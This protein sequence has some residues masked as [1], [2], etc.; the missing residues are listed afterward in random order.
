MIIKGILKKGEYFD[1]ISLMIVAGRITEMD[2][3]QDSAVVMGT[4]ENKAILEA[5]GFLIDMFKDA[6]DTDLLIAVKGEDEAVVLT[7]LDKAEE[8]LARLR[9]KE[10]KAGEFNP[11]SIEGAVKALPGANLALIS[12]AGKYAAQEAC[13]A[14]GMGL[15]VMIFSDNVSLKDEIRLK[16]Y[17]REHNLLVMGPDCGTAI[18]NGVPLGFA[19]AVKRGNIGVIAA[20]G[21]GLQEVTCLIHNGGGGIS[22]AVGTGGRD[23]KEEVGGITFIAALE[24]LAADDF[25][26]A[27]LLV[28]KPPHP[29]VLKKIGETVKGISKPVAAV[30]LG[31]E[32]AD[33]EAFGMAAE[34]TLQQGAEKILELAG[35]K[36]KVPLRFQNEEDMAKTAKEIAAKLK[37][38][39]KYLRALF[40]GGT[41]CSETQVLLKGVPGV[42]SNTPTAGSAPLEDIFTSREHTVIDLGDDDFTVG[43]P[44]PMIDFSIRNKRLPLEAVDTGTAVIL[45]DLV[46]G[47]GANPDP[48]P[49]LV[50]AVEEAQRAARGQ[51]REVPIICSV[52]GTDEDPQHRGRVIEAL[53]E[54]GVIICGS[55][56]EASRLC[57]EIIRIAGAR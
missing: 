53:E 43:R 6:E 1:S 41:F 25:T 51:G 9:N 19:N 46:L 14:L 52:T 2:G 5:S 30:F 21:T 7:V 29:E 27:L 50:P 17:G 4:R 44:H 42:Y 24:A 31:A 49:E 35:G 18:I 11:K 28:S 3:V 55:N 37:P 38:G 56:A 34:P 40:T 15:N 8:E 39:Q 45:L 22:Q 26:D 10:A 16:T 12:I 33:I 48:L 32:A 36:G 20:S 23:V 47:Y 13:N 57:W 54:A